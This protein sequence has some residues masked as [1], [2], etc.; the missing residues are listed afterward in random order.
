MKLLNS[1]T[2]L[3]TVAATVGI[4]AHA[5][6]FA[7]WNDPAAQR[8]SAP[9]IVQES[10]VSQVTGFAPWARVQPGPRSES[11]LTVSAFAIRTGFTP[12]LKPNG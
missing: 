1:K 4:H 7:P 9:D 10:T 2:V 6:G 8:K 12:W 3:F 5:A 11:S